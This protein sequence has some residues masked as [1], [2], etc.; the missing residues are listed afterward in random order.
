MTLYEQIL[1][2]DPVL[3]R[4]ELETIK[5]RAEIAKRTSKQLSN[6]IGEP[7]P[8][9]RPQG[10]H[11]EIQST[12]QVDQV[13][14][15]NNIKSREDLE[16]WS[17]QKR[18]ERIAELLKIP[19]IREAQ[20]EHLKIKEAERKNQERENSRLDKTTDKNAA[21]YDRSAEIEKAQKD[22]TQKLQEAKER[23]NERDRGR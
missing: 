17:L 15:K 10:D 16:R 5:K 9:M 14:R 11:S 4:I 20:I 12:R 19:E 23:N 6:S 2:E 3:K 22:F 7:K 1:K 21:R 8:Q 13:I 18:E